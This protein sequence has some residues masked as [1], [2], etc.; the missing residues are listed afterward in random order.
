MPEDYCKGKWWGSCAFLFFGCASPP[1]HVCLSLLKGLCYN[2][3]PA[4]G[5][6]S[7]YLVERELFWMNSCVCLWVIVC[8]LW[9]VCTG[10]SDYICVSVRIRLW[11]CVY[12]LRAHH[13]WYLTRVGRG[14][15]G[16]YFCFFSCC[17]V[18]LSL[19]FSPP[20]KKNNPCRQIC[21]NQLQHSLYYVCTKVIFLKEYTVEKT[22]YFFKI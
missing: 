21:T 15:F 13:M 18:F 17:T 22:I 10:Q 20:P 3:T 11:T 1:F 19:S 8:V 7:K 2:Y 9:S 4:R 16:C 14:C 6:E 12:W 5:S